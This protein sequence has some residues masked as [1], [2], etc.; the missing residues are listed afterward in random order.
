MQASSSVSLMLVRFWA[1]K[2]AYTGGTCMRL[3]TTGGGERGEVSSDM[4][5]E[6]A[7]TRTVTRYLRDVNHRAT[8]SH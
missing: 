8:V 5:K 6:H 3:N 4:P 7:V 1:A 2:C